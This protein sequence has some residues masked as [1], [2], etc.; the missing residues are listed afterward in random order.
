[1]KKSFDQA[2]YARKRM[3]DTICNH[4]DVVALAAIVVLGIAMRYGT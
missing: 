3:I 4:L 2:I 1:M